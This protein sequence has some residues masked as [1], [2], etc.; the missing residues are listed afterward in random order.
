[1]EST[2]DFF[3][4]PVG[5]SNFLD[6][7]VE[8]ENIAYN[9]LNY[10]NPQTIFWYG[11]ILIVFIF[12]ST[13]INFNYS[14]LIGLIFYAI[15]IYYLYTDKKVEY[16]DTFEKL[17]DKYS[18]LNTNNNI[19][20]KYPNIIDFL[21]YMTEFKE[22]S[23][24]IYLEI[25]TLFEN[26]ILMYESCLQDINLINKNFL[27]LTTTKNKIMYTI[28][29]F[30]FNILSN[31]PTIKLYHM[32]KTV[33]NMLNDFLEELLTIQKK[34]LY[35][36]GY[37]TKTQLIESS[38]VLPVNYFDYQNQYVRNTKQYDVMNLLLT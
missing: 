27:S 37:N 8:T 22:S 19:L 20:K 31:S 5:F 15:F 13:K 9:I 11:I 7:Y 25:E 3:A 29:F 24:R 30:T 1:M 28:N 34:D 17:N 32:R 6:E 23:P 26:F 33:E 18:M 35:Y 4:K 36:N 14:L 16:I 38:N 10:Q 21:Y 2:I 12:F